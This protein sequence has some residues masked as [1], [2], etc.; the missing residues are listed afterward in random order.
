VLPGK[1]SGGKRS[2]PEK[3][4]DSLSVQCRE[5][6]WAIEVAAQVNTGEKPNVGLR[7]MR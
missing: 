2:S 1:R 6:V 4:K 3:S 5:R 7:L